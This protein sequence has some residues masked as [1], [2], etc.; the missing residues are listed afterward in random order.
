M[1]GNTERLIDLDHVKLLRQMKNTEF[2]CSAPIMVQGYCVV[3]ECVKGCICALFAE[4]G[5]T[6]LNFRIGGRC[7]PAANCPDNTFDRG[8]AAGSAHRKQPAAGK[9]S[10][11]CQK[12]C[13]CSAAD[14]MTEQTPVC[15]FCPGRLEL[16][17][18]YPLR[19]A[20]S[21]WYT[22]LPFSAMVRVPT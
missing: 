5:G 14:H 3:C 18:A 7:G 2:W 21:E 16:L 22:C 1:C 12:S 8:R 19:S 11:T 20:G 17:F 9:R 6:L 13:F 15:R 10:Q 4:F